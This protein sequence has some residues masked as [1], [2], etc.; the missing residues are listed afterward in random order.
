[1]PPFIAL[2][3]DQW[4]F[5]D[6]FGRIVQ[7]QRP[8]TTPLTTIILYGR[9]SNSYAILYKTAF[10]DN[11]INGWY[12]QSNLEK[13]PQYV[14]LSSKFKMKKTRVFLYDVTK[15][16]ISGQLGIPTTDTCCNIVLFYIQT[17]FKKKAVLSCTIRR[18]FSATIYNLVESNETDGFPFVLK[19]GV[20]IL[21][22]IPPDVITGDLFTIEGIRGQGMLVAYRKD[23]RYKSVNYPIKQLRRLDPRFEKRLRFNHCS[24]QLFLLNVPDHHAI[25]FEQIYIPRNGLVTKG[26]GKTTFHEIPTFF[27]HLRKQDGDPN[28][29]WF[30]PDGALL[31]L[32]RSPRLTAD[33]TEQIT[34]VDILKSHCRN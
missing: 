16:T 1:V 26:S 3:G 29:F 5:D 25:G 18:R 2:E 15:G 14:L 17:G 13:H 10:H 22:R 23:N 31:H 27:L 32:I 19:N 34:S 9:G 6:K 30:N 8:R 24:G 20:D 4:Y 12:R 21:M 7:L 11:R 33:K 28:H